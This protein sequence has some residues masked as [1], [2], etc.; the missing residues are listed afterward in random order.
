MNFKALLVVFTLIGLVTSTFGLGCET[1]SL[2]TIDNTKYMCE[3][4]GSNKGPVTCEECNI[5]QDNTGE[6]FLCTNID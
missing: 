6:C 2:D 4:C 1:C 3:N 5:M